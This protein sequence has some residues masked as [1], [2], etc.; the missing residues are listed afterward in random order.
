MLAIFIKRSSVVGIFLINAFMGIG[1]V[2]LTPF[3]CMA[4]IEASFPVQESISINVFYFFA[5]IF[6]CAGSNLAT[7]EGIFLEIIKILFL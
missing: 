7:I 6:S 1:I 3:A 2:G 4:L 5:S